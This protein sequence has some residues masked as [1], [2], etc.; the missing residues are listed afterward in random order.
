LTRRGALHRIRREGAVVPPHHDASTSELA[1][2]ISISLSAFNT[3][4]LPRY[5]RI[6]PRFASG[7]QL[8]VGALPGPADDLADL[9]LS[10]RDLGRWAL[11]AQRL[12]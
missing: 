6:Y 9:A 10:D 1:A 4:T 5:N 3:L 11:K 8:L 7:A 2:A 12:P